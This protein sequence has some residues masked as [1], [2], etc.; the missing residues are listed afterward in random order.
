MKALVIRSFGG[1]EAL[2][3]ADL[4]DPVPG[5]GEIR[6][7]VHAVA[8]ARTKDVAA[9]AGMPPFAEQIPAL[10]HVLGAE[11]AGVVDRV[12][13]DADADLVGSRVVVSAVLSC[14]QCRA[15]R[16]SREEACAEFGLVGIHRQGSYAQ[17]CVVPVDNVRTIPA[18]VSFTEAAALAANG[19]V[20]SAQLDAGDVGPGDTVLVPGAG[21]ALGATV[22]ALA[23][24]RGARVIGVDR[25]DQNPRRLDGLPLVALDGSDPDLSAR[26]LDAA[27]NGGLNC[28]VDNLGI[29]ALCEA[30]LPALGDL[31]RV[32]V[33]GAISHDPV[34]I[35]LLQFYL[36]SQS[37]IGVR[38]GNRHQVDRLWADVAA[39]FRPPAGFVHA[40]PWTQASD[41]HLS[42]QSGSSSGQLVLTVEAP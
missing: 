26:I 40:M 12:G 15:C 2:E 11:H 38:T 39:G 3:P 30:Y 24:F 31:G 25:L 9:R 21:G 7:R 32:V 13:P 6:V 23:A 20:A 22:A 18:E 33:S 37:L 28:V 41:A 16:M 35:R 4:P 1:P 5:P 19:A 10:P 27:G 8:V 34:P 17:Y 42:I 29:T 14:S 36:R